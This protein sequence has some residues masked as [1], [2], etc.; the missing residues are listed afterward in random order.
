LR[1]ASSSAQSSSTTVPQIQ[2]VQPL[3]T[4]VPLQNSSNI[5]VTQDTDAS[6]QDLE[7]QL[8]SK[9]R[10]LE[11]QASLEK[12]KDEQAAAAENSTLVIRTRAD[13]LLKEA[14]V[15]AT[16]AKEKNEQAVKATKERAEADKKV[17]GLELQKQE[18]QKFLKMTTAE[19]KE[20][21]QKIQVLRRKRA[22]ALQAA[23][24]KV[25]LKTVVAVQS[26]RQSA[27]LVQ[28]SPLKPQMPLAPH[29]AGG[30]QIPQIANAQVPVPTATVLATQ[31][32]QLPQSSVR[33]T[34]VTQVSEATQ[35]GTQVVSKDSIDLQKLKAENE[36][37]KD[38]KIAL[39]QQLVNRQKADEKEHLRRRL[40]SRLVEAD[41]HLKKRH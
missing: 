3:R 10:E 16:I 8:V 24:G 40:K 23:P 4:P 33:A 38:E 12:E 41:H 29:K 36:R 7:T 15:A 26:A 11:V 2:S 37:L 5:S 17:Q 25:T 20:I 19:Q 14:D 28:S 22:S 39:Q 6:L 35:L 9:K 27:P 18:T 21:E 30:V 1:Q 32:T 34:H 31:V 13:E